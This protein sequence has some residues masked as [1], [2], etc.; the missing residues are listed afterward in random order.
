[1]LGWLRRII[2]GER[3]KLPM[4]IVPTSHPVQSR[5]AAPPASGARIINRYVY[6]GRNGG[7]DRTARDVEY[8]GIMERPSAGFICLAVRIPG[9]TRRHFVEVGMVVKVEIAG[10]IH[11]PT[12]QRERHEETAA[13]LRAFIEG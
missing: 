11:R 9:S 6:W 13:K 1:M 2:G 8:L 7:D 10:R 5:P 3:E 12:L 4:P